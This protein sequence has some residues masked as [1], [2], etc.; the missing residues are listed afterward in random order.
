MAGPPVVTHDFETRSAAS[1]NARGS[2][3]YS[4]HP[5]TSAMCLAYNLPW[6]GDRVRL[7]HMAHPSQLIAESD[8]PEELFRAIRDGCLFE[9]HNAFFER[10]IWRGVMMP[11]HGWPLIPDDRYRCSAAKASAA[12]LPRALE[13]AV[14]AIHLSIRK[15]MVGN[16]LMK[17]MCKPRKLSGKERK[18]LR[19]EG[20]D[21]DGVVWWHEDEEDLYRLWEYCAD[22]VRAEKAFSGATRDLSDYELR[23]WQ[24]DQELNERG[25]RIDVDMARAALLIA[26]EWK[27]KLNVEMMEFT[28]FK[29]TQRKKVK[30]WL[31]VEEDVHLP[32]TAAPTLEYFM[33]YEPMSSRARRVVRIIRE[34]NRTSTSKYRSML[35][36][37]GDDDRVRDI[38]MYCGAD[39]TGRWAGKG[40]QVH[41]FPARDLVIKDFDEA[42]ALIKSGDMELCHLLYGDVI[43][44]LSHALRGAIVASPGRDLIVADYAAIEARVVLWLAGATSA[45]EVFRGG[46]DIYCDMATGIYG[47][48][49]IKGEH[50]TERQFGKQAILGLGFGMG[51]IT[52]LL[53]CRRYNI[54]FTVGQVERIMGRRRLESV[55]A[56]VAKYLNLGT[57]LG[58]PLDTN[59]RRQAG[60]ARYRLTDAREDPEAVVHELALMKHTVGIYRSRYSEVKDLWKDQEAA[61]ILAVR[62]GTEVSCGLVSWFVDGQFLHCRL[63]SGR[64]LHYP[65]PVVK[66]TRTSWGAIHNSL[67]Y[68]GK[69]QL[70]REWMRIGTYGGKVVENMTQ[71]VARDIMAHA[72]L[73]AHEHDVYDPVM[74]VHDELVCEVDKDK[75]SLDEFS[76]L[77]SA[78]Q[79][80]A[81]GCP[82]DAEA[83]RFARYRKM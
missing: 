14:K 8:P 38:M 48:Q 72:M 71:A 1:L 56:W 63:P 17:K 64:L 78:T 73:L 52:F 36:R 33:E 53:T 49:V 2:H 62:S 76:R 59:G 25:V 9:A 50:G 23:V 13:D 57:Y 10:M 28:G 35:Q 31:A 18:E 37:V 45:L 3:V 77:M 58:E 81:D 26:D 83:G 79:S 66:P 47:Y 75:G 7:W 46:G 43:Q 19:T 54:H 65:D 21:P 6:E 4:R 24:M 67:S 30:E 80:W 74:S 82:I 51:F 32:D 22:D 34:V 5:T 12:S 70:T 16:T 27:T 20:I 40:I 55:S 69:G 61:A 11:R 15:D 39:R 41:N 60:R 44:L 68:M 42:A 29:G